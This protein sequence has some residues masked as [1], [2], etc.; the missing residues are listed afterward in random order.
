MR[1][2]HS[3]DRPDP[4]KKSARQLELPLPRPAGAKTALTA[5]AAACLGLIKSGAGKLSGI[6]IAAKLSGDRALKA[7]RMLSD[8]GLAERKGPQR[9]LT[10][11]GRGKRARIAIVKPKALA[12]RGPKA[13]TRLGGSARRMLE[14]LETPMGARQVAEAIG[15]TPQRVM[16]LL[17][18]LV[19]AGQLR[20]G[21]AAAP[22]FI[23]ALAGDAR[24]LLNRH[25]AR[26]LS[27]L[28]E[29]D[30]APLGAVAAASHLARK[31]A[32]IVLWT[33][34]EAGLAIAETRDLWRLSEAGARHFQRDVD[35][36]RAAPVRLPVHSD[37]I[38]QVLTALK[39]EGPA[40]AM[41]LAERLAVPRNSMNALMQYLKRRGL[42]RKTGLSAIAPHAITALGR[43][44][45]DAT[46][47]RKNANPKNQR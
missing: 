12:P 39:N 17:L 3:P 46:R 24:R 7:I 13:G 29:S 21:D 16:Q 36:R 22:S 5:D 41:E 4:V 18:R 10:A 28:P 45:L 20:T 23:I 6:A 25:E 37:R 47:R 38:M 9:L 40:R 8:L 30:P 32:D 26:L 33:L 44:T 11:T 42:V 19:S 2:L 34:A 35:R 1:W 14:A 27:V 43:E 31:E 15:V